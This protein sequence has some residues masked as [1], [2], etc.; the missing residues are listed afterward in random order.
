MDKGTKDGLDGAYGDIHTGVAEKEV[1]AGFSVQRG[2]ARLDGK[3]ADNVFNGGSFIFI[4]PAENVIDNRPAIIHLRI[5]PRAGYT[6][7]AV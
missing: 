3:L 1:W 7:T 6:N 5:V 4:H 2:I